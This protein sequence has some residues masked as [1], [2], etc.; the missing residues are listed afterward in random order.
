MKTFKELMNQLDENAAVY[1]SSAILSSRVARLAQR[2]RRER[3]PKR[4]DELIAQQ[5]KDIAY[6]NGIN[7]SI[8][9]KGVKEIKDKKK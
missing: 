1:A 6:M 5:N 2:I 3:D 8:I 9:S 7:T 4:R